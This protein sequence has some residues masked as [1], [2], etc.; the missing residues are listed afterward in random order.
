VGFIDYGE[1]KTRV[2]I[3]D[4]IAKLG[5][6]L[7]PAGHQL[8][9]FCPKCM[10]GGDRALVVTPGKGLFYCF[11]AKTGGDQIALVAHLKELKTNEAA[12]WLAG[13]VP[14]NKTVTRLSGTIPPAPPA[15]FDPSKYAESLKTEGAPLDETTCKTWACGMAVKGVLRGRLALPVSDLAG[16]VLAY[17]GRDDTGHYAYPN[18]FDPAAHIFGAHKLETGEVRILSEPLEVIQAFESGVQ[19]LCFLTETV[20]AEQVEQLAAVLDQKKCELVF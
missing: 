2:S 17:I 19:A 15:K 8:R 12:N 3:H 9:G 10:Q 4:A 16:N 1:L 20:T 18:G 11:A 5:L 13:T 7:K 6:E 14:Q